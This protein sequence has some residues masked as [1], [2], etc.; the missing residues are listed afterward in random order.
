MNERLQKLELEA[1]VEVTRWERDPPSGYKVK[2]TVKE[3]SRE[4]FA[5]LIV[6]EC[7]FII[8]DERKPEMVSQIELWKQIKEHFGV[9]R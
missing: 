3:F 2:V 6:R 5:E 4:K 7:L 8:D 1:Y 9:D